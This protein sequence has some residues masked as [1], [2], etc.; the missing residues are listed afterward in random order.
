MAQ[1]AM[2]MLT[3]F[4]LRQKID[5]IQAMGL[6]PFQRAKLLLR[7][8]KVLRG[9]DTSLKRIRE[10]SERSGD[11]RSHAGLQRLEQHIH[12]FHEE[13]VDLAFESLHAT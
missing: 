12:Q 6:T 1:V 3:E 5:T 10:Q 4:G 11:R 13:V 2:R 8:A 9:R 7:V